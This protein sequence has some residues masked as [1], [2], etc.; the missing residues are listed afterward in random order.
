MTASPSHV[1][2]TRHLSV[3]FLAAGA[4]CFGLGAVSF[5]LSRNVFDPAAFG[6][7]AADS[8]SDPGVAA[9]A[10]DLVTDRIIQRKPDLI[11][12]RPILVTASETVIS[13]NAFRAVVERA[14]ARA[15]DAAFSQASQRVLLS[16]PDLNVLVHEA[17]INASPALAAKIPA[18]IDPTIAKL[19]NSGTPGFILKLARAG[20]V[21][22]FAW[23]LFFVLGLGLYLLAIWVAADRQRTMAR[24]GFAL[25]IAGLAVAGLVAAN[26]LAGIWFHDPGTIGL[27]RGLWRAF[28][29]DLNRWGLLFMVVGVLIA[30]GASSLLEKLDPFDRMAA[31]ARM[32]VTP[33]NTNRGRLL[34]GAGLFL[35]GCLTVAY[36]VMMVSF[37]G[38]IAGVCLAYTGTRELFRLF[39]ER[40]EQIPQLQAGARRHRLGYWALAAA[41]LVLTVGAAWLVWRT[42]A[43]T[44]VAASTVLAC[45]GFPELCDRRVDQVVF[46]G[47]HNA[48]SNQD[49]PGWMFPHHEA[50]MPQMLRDGIRALLIDIHYGYHG[51]ARIKTDMR[52]EPNAETMKKAI[53]EEGYAAAMRIRDRL[54]GVDESHHGLYFCHGFCELGAYPVGAALREIRDFVVAHPNEVIILIVEDYVIPGELA[55]EFD[56]AGFTDLMYTGTV[57]PPWPTL[58]HLIESGR[59]VLVF[60]ESGRPG[61]PW[62]RPAFQT[63]RE[64]PYT[65]HK[66]EDFSCRANR[67]GDTGSLFQINHWID[68]TPA[69]KPS[70]AA[71]VNAYDFL[72][73]RA[74]K[75]EAQRRH[76]PNIIAVDFYRTGDLFAVVNKLNGVGQPDEASSQSQ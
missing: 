11:A 38:V 25:V 7:R 19:A 46:A 50:G 22:R 14:A 55:A 30:S 8:L 52:M 33:P 71:I 75:C 72:L 10:A 20:R 41:M 3:P 23:P 36:P 61:V 27:V 56:K 43:E 63:F 24:C 58:R 53:G 1:R 17:L 15:H 13:S 76:L 40:F 39:L 5:I 59:R 69:P 51:G 31:F 47:A 18:S 4:V 73:A 74:E 45:N 35:A 64:T 67:G 65:F 28:L 70:N 62:L 68:T 21:L 2:H 44:P 48:M 37:A 34:W 57:S 6:R 12:F 49:A 29:G 32:L 16:L 42:P 54:I 9:Y 66:V 26:P 60:I